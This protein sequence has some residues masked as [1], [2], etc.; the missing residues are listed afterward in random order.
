MYKLVGADIC[1]VGSEEAEEAYGDS[2]RKGDAFSDSAADGVDVEEL[3]FVFR[4]GFGE[5]YHIFVAVPDERHGDGEESR[6]DQLA[7]EGVIG[8]GIFY[9]G[10]AEIFREDVFT[11]LDLVSHYGA[12]HIGVIVVDLAMEDLLQ[13]FSDLGC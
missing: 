4:F 5:A 11:V 9:F 2:G 13:T 8:L 12:F 3:G 6:G 10:I 7:G 1:E